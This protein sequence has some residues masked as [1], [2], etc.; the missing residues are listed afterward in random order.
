MWLRVAPRAFGPVP[1][2]PNTLVATTT[3]SRAH[4]QVLQR[5][6]GDLLG[7]AAGVDVGGVD[8][9]DAGV[10]R[11]APTMRSASACCSW[12]ILPQMPSSPPPKVMVPRQ[13]SETKRPVRPRGLSFMWRSGSRGSAARGR[14]F[15]A[16]PTQRRAGRGIA[17]PQPQPAS[18]RLALALQPPDSQLPLPA[19]GWKALGMAQPVNST[20]L[21]RP[22]RHATTNPPTATTAST[23][24]CGRRGFAG[25]DRAGAVRRPA[26]GRAVCV[27]MPPSGTL[28]RMRPLMAQPLASR[29]RPE[30][31]LAQL[32]PGDQHARPGD[33]QH[34]A[35]QPPPGSTSPGRRTWRRRRR[36][37]R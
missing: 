37:R 6:A 29:M 1:V 24:R 27:S 36:S 17:V 16:A 3:S 18:R 7:A 13:S 30:A 33:R 12:P 32:E 19:P 15:Y 2:S 8:E 9:V 21:R 10:E 34:D 28:M 31:A 22:I 25:T 35:E 5:L 11:A 20:P 14:S 23:A 26:A 4:L